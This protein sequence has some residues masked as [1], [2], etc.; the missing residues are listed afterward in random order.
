VAIASAKETQAAQ[1]FLRYAGAD[2]H[3]NYLILAVVAWFHAESG[4]LS[5]VIG[6]NPFNIRPG[7]ASKLSSGYRV[8]KN[9][10]GRFL[11]FPTLDAGFRAAALVL[12]A[13]APSYGYGL[14]LKALKRGSAVDF[15]VALALSQWDAGH[16]GV[17]NGD[18]AADPNDNNLL[19]IYSRY[20]GLQ[21]PPP[22]SP[23]SSPP[24]G[25]KPPPKPRP[26]PH[27]LPKVPRVLQPPPPMRQYTSGYAART[28]YK[29]R[30]PARQRLDT[31]R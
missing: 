14:V 2:S 29:E 13:L 11:I 31:D 30:H 8:S 19:R 22:P 12:T 9:G 27:P 24:G 23:S 4:G 10:N 6:N 3:N 25:T 16:Y 17:H 26:K 15:L 1:A 5:G 7:I 28:F 20:S 18:N 21:L